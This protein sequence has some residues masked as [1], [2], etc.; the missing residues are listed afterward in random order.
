M[1]LFNKLE[2][3][4]NKSANALSIFTKT[5]EDL[6]NINESIKMEIQK[7]TD[8]INVLEAENHEYDNQRNSNVNIINKI[9]NILK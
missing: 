7:N 6:K 9:E 5:V 2:S 4:K 8:Q 1:I 3:L